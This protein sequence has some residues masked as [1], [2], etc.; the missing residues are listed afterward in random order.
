[1]RSLLYSCAVIGGNYPIILHGKQL[2]LTWPLGQK[3]AWTGMRFC[4]VVFPGRTPLTC[5]SLCYQPNILKNVNLIDIHDIERLGNICSCHHFEREDFSAKASRPVTLLPKVSLNHLSIMS[6]QFLGTWKLISSE[7]F[8]EYMKELGVCYSQ[9]KLGSLAKPTVVIT[10]NKDVITI[11]TE[12]I[13]K[14]NEVSFRLG[15]EFEE[16]T[17]DCRHAKECTMNDVTCTRIYARV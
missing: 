13:F 3:K 17:M 7:N 10:K 8:D 6:E 14:V 12:T 2:L 15:Q 4:I 5:I 11:R 16:T 1:M 9:R